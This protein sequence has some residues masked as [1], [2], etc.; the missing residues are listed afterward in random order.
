[1]SRKVKLISIC[2]F[3]AV[4]WFAFY[5]PNL[6]AEETENTEIEDIDEF[7]SC[8]YPIGTS[9]E[10][11]ISA[12]PGTVIG[13]D[14]EGNEYKLEISW[15]IPQDFHTDAPG[16][17]AFC[18]ILPENTYSYKI[19]KIPELHIVIFEEQ[20]DESGNEMNNMLGEQVV[21]D[22]TVNMGG[23]TAP[24]G[25]RLNLLSQPWGVTKNDMSFSWE[26]SLSGNM[27]KQTGYRIVISQR[28]SQ[29]EKGEYVF[30]SGWKDGSENTSVLMDLSTILED[31]ELYYWQVQIK[32]TEGLESPFS[33]PQAFSTETDWT[34]KQGI[35]GSAG[36]RI[37]FLRRELD[38]PDNVEKVVLSA[39]AL[40]GTKSRQ[41]VYNLYVN[42]VEIGLGPTRANGQKLDYDTYDLTEYVTSGSNTVGVIVYSEDNSAFLCQMTAYMEDGTKQILT[43]TGYDRMNWRTLDGDNIFIGSSDSS[44]G[45]NYYSAVQDNIDVSLYPSGWDETG[46]DMSGWKIPGL[47]SRFSGYILRPSQNDIYKHYEV[48]PQSIQKKADGSFLVDFGREIIGTIRLNINGTNADVTFQYGEQL[49]ENGNAQYKM[50]TGNTYQETWKIKNGPQEISG[51]GMKTFRYVTILNMPVDLTEDQITG[52]TVRSAFDENAS[53]F[54]S[55]NSILNDLYDMTKY[56]SKMTT[57]GLYVDTQNRERLAYEGDTLI[58]GMTSFSYSPTSTAFKYSAEYLLDNT[59][60]PSEYSIYN[61]MAIYKHYLYTGDKRMLEEAYQALKSKTMEQFFDSSQG[62]M[63]RAT[64]SFQHI[65]VDWPASDSD[66]YRIADAYYNTVFNAVCVGGYEDM[67]SIAEVL[68]EESDKLYYQNLADTIRENM[69]QKLYDRQTGEFYDGLSQ[70][71]TVVQHSA[72]HATAYAL[73]FGIY[74]SRDMSNKM[75]AAIEEDGELKMSVYGSYFLLQGL[76]DS[77]HGM[78]ARKIMSNPDDEMGVRSWAYMMYGLDATIT[79]EA[80]NYANKSNMSLSHAWGSAPGSMLVRGMFGIQ[81]TSPGF[82][83]FDVKIQPGGVADASVKIPTMKGKIE[84]SYTLENSGYIICHIRVPANSAASLYLPVQTGNGEIIVNGSAVTAL[85]DKEGYTGCVLEGGEYTVEVQAGIFADDSEFVKTDVVTD[86]YSGGVWAGERTNGLIQ[87][88]IRGNDIEAVKVRIKNAPVS[89]GIQ[90]SA[91]MQSYEWQGECSDGQVSGIPDGNKRLE[92][93]EMELTGEM[94]S[95]YDIYYRTYVKGWG[96][97]DW[98]QNGEPAGSSGYS[99]SILALEARLVEKGGEA[100]GDREQPYKTT[101]RM[102]TYSTHVQGYGW[103]AEVGDG[104]VSGTVGE[105]KRLEAVKIHASV[106]G[107][108]GG[109]QYCTHVQSYGW[110]DWVMNG[111]MSGTSGKSKRLEAIKIKLSGELAERYDIYYRVHAQSYGW[112]GWAKNGEEA[113]TEEMAKRLEG[114]QIRLVRKGSTA[115]GSTSGH[116][117]TPKVTYQTHVQSYGWQAIVYDGEI[118]GTEGERKRLEAVKIQLYNPEVSGSLQYSTHVQSYGWQGWSQNGQMSGTSGEGKRLEAIKIRLTGQVEEKYDIYYRVHAQS[119]G[120]LGWAKNGQEA[121]TEGMAKRLEA[122]QI[123]LVEKGGAAPGETTGHFHSAQVAYKTHVQSYGWQSEVFNGAVSGTEGKGKRLEAITVRNAVP[124]VQGD[125]LYR[126]HIQTYGWETSWRKN[127]QISG[128]SGESKRLEAICIKLD[129]ELAEKYDVYYRVHVESYGWLGWA[130]NGDPAGTEGMGKRLEGIQIQYVESGGEAPGNTER[131]YLMW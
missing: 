96:W 113:G 7:D 12:L 29:V 120:W 68:G 126:T 47:N 27:G 8:E 28:E 91:Y 39:T 62:L 38:I 2:F 57:Q 10:D 21:N 35:W 85:R 14:R 131:P 110:Q 95:R 37:V 34:S 116:F 55:S 73:A 67:A 86:I 15:E 122:I 123:E 105:A 98:A 40:D 33:L 16:E 99:R 66:S 71:G 88:D 53:D 84:V 58:T 121:G 94:N 36:E 82:K 83:T 59:T 31:G 72:Q 80:W 108:S 24:S 51:I 1:M 4:M 119:Y 6:Y 87:G 103:Q 97:M 78:L 42:G 101:D 20:P 11:I 5:L 41:Y 127:G 61:I 17:Y 124:G 115:P 52:L 43:N 74:N 60:W 90:Y 13:Y 69:V 76:Y 18:P 70:D 128:R 100:P 56:T 30:D 109:V 117:V 22:I 54:E 102:I 77:D 92:A 112:L 23:E 65:M 114:I 89:G 64:T 111:E 107:V 25:L 19:E 9:A 93:V 50:A 49:D 75:A 79:S 125:I 32:N 3:A 106:A 63:G 48:M 104:D 118:S 44:I 129:G 26:N 130:K 45:T 81:P 46:F